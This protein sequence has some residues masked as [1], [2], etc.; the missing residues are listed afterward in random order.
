[1]ASEPM[2]VHIERKP[3]TEPERRMLIV[4]LNYNKELAP[5]SEDVGELT[6]IMDGDT[7]MAIAAKAGIQDLVFMRDDL[8]HDDELYPTANNVK[9]QMREMGSRCPPGDT[10]IFHFSGHGVNVPD[11]PPMDEDDGMDEAFVT[12]TP[13][14]TVDPDELLIDDVFTECLKCYFTP[15]VAMLCITDCC[16]SGT[17]VDVDSNLWDEGHQV[18]AISAAMDTETDSD[19]GYGGALTIAISETMKELANNSDYTVQDVLNRVTKKV[20]KI[21]M[22]NQ[23]QQEVNVQH[24]NLEPVEMRWP[25]QP[26]AY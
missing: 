20:H 18:I 17:I 12:V 6:S 1:L 4:C 24:A 11:A 9:M 10:F 21:G 2:R 25:L 23:N 8:D 3:G 26:L 16:H 5:W 15:G 14:Y 19:T 22:D 7:M 13:E